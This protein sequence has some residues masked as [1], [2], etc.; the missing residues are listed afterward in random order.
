MHGYLYIWAGFGRKILL[1][2]YKK[3]KERGNVFGACVVR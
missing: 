3:D 2:F 1:V